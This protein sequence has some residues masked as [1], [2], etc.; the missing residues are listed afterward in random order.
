M[1]EVDL[2]P[3]IRA[4]FPGVTVRIDSPS[5]PGISDLVLVGRRV[6]IFAE[7]K[8]AETVM[9]RLYVTAPQQRFLQQVEAAGGCGCVLVYVRGER[10][11]YV[12]LPKV[13]DLYW[14]HNRAK[15]GRCLGPTVDHLEMHLNSIRQKNGETYEPPSKN[16]MATAAP[17]AVSMFRHPVQHE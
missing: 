9:E 12:V 4:E 10:A 14:P 6:T 1:R 17:A 15:H 11:W 5:R 2:Y 8:I 16:V 13:L 7:I 3:R